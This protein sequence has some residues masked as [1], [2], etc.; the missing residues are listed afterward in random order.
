M[1]GTCRPTPLAP[2]CRG[3][4]EGPWGHGAIAGGVSLTSSHTDEAQ[5]CLGGGGVPRGRRGS[6]GWAR[7]C[8]SG[9]KNPPLPSGFQRDLPMLP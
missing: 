6:P 4:T 9:I 1:R 5:H 2:C 8:C 7:T 3:E